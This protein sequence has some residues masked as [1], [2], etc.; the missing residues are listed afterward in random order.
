MRKTAYR[1][2]TSDA[3]RA[4]LSRTFVVN[5]DPVVA[6]VPAPA[7]FAQKAALYP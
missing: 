6:G 2:H 4:A 5:R 1:K 7:T 3:I